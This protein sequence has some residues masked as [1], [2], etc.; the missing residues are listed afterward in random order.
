MSAREYFS[1]IYFTHLQTRKLKAESSSQI[2]DKL[3]KLSLQ[4]LASPPPAK[5]IVIVRP[6]FRLFQ[7][8]PP[9]LREMILATAAGLQKDYNLCYDGYYSS[10]RKTKGS[11]PISLSTMFQ[12]SKRI[13]EH[14]VPY[15][16]HSTDFHFGLT[17]FTNFLWQAGPINRPRIRKLTFH[18]GRLA[19]LH[20]IR[21]LAPDLVFELLEPPVVTSPRSLQYFWRCQIQDLAR[22]LNISTLTIDVKGI[23]P[24]DLVMIARIMKSAF[25]SV[26]RF[27]FIDTDNNGFAQEVKSS[28]LSFGDDWDATTWRQSCFE[29][30]ER[31]CTHQYFFK[32]ELMRLDREEVK[33][34]MDV[35]KDKQD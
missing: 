35:D 17:G 9:E 14:F 19:L 32:F 33:S 11:S 31:H 8:L 2:H 22:E 16:Y 21:W 24:V 15:V 30:W 13:N 26:Q 20:C 18:F 34:L 6:L 10:K 23:P 28:A 4:P 12:I 5:D 3:S 7:N 1:K 25:A 29:Y 27:R